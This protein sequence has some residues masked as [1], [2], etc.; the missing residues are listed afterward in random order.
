MCSK[1]HY[2]LFIE[3]WCLSRFILEIAFPRNYYLL[4]TFLNSLFV[5]NTHS[6]MFHLTTK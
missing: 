3:R 2:H 6:S 4:L 1:T 5:T